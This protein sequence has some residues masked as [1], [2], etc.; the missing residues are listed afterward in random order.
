MSNIRTEDGMVEVKSPSRPFPLGAKREL[1]ETADEVTYDDERTAYL[2]S[3][4][5]DELL[6]RWELHVV[7]HDDPEEV[8]EHGEKTI[9]IY[10]ERVEVDGVEEDFNPDEARSKMEASERF[11]K[12]TSSPP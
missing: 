9:E 1:A 12:L 3:I 10:E 6:D 11:T 4:P 8:W 7:K 5:D 2:S